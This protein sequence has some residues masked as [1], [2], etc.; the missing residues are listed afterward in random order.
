Q[1]GMKAV[2]LHTA[3]KLIPLARFYHG[4]G[5]YVYDVTPAAGYRRGLFVKELTDCG[6]M[7]F[8]AVCRNV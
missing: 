3:V 1:R 6:D 2:A 7:D 5:F 4:M 8:S